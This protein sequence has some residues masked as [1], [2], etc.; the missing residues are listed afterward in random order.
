MQ[1]TASY[2]LVVRWID[3]CPVI[4]SRCTAVSIILISHISLY[5]LSILYCMQENNFQVVLAT[6]G[7][8]SFAVFTYKCGELNWSHNRASIGFSASS[9]VFA[10]HRLSRLLNVNDIACL[11]SPSPPWSNVVYQIDEDGMK[12]ICFIVIAVAALYINLVMKC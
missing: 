5:I 1:F 3:V 9:S 6:D 7:I 2:L 4:N 11:E 8:Q 10:N 12:V